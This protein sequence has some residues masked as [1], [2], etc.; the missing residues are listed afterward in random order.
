MFLKILIKFIQAIEAVQKGEL[1]KELINYFHNELIPLEKD[2]L[3]VKFREDKKIIQL[4]LEIVET[5]DKNFSVSDYIFPKKSMKYKILS[6]MKNGYNGILILKGKQILGYMWYTDKKNRIIHPDITFLQIAMKSGSVYIFDL[7]ICKELRGSN[8]STNFLN[9]ALF[10][11][12]QKGYK[13]AHGYYSADNVSSLW[14]HRT[15][16]FTESPHIKRIRF[17]NTHKLAKLNS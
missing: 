7:L 10:Q 3:Q 4:D 1:K 5:S 15:L 8:F 17:L 13:T 11:L 9:N 16:G 12:K 2:L 6:Y 14:L